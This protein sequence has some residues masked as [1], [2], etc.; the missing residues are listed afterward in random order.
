L[1][2]FHG[3]PGL[4]VVI[5]ILPGGRFFACEIKRPGNALTPL[6]ASFLDLVNAAGGLGICV[7]NLDQLIRAIDLERGVAHE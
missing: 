1:Y 4:S 6:Q 3:M 5:G 2:A 7:H